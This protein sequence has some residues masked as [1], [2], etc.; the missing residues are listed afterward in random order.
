[1]PVD[2]KL[3]AADADGLTAQQRH[4]IHLGDEAKTKR[5]VAL[6]LA[7]LHPVAA[8][9]HEAPG[10]RFLFK[11]ALA[12]LEPLIIAWRDAVTNVGQDYSHDACPD[13][14]ISGFTPGEWIEIIAQVKAYDG[15]SDE[16][17]VADMDAVDWCRVMDT[18]AAEI[19]LGIYLDPVERD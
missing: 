4:A 14:N 11:F 18:A 2:L 19:N 17:Q 8:D 9:W 15:G 6:A 13:R 12:L 3:S 7:A 16:D 5:Q 1:M 10:K